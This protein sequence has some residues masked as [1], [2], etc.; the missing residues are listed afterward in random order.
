MLLIMILLMAGRRAVAVVDIKRRFVIVV[1]GIANSS[2]KAT[3]GGERGPH[4]PLRVVRPKNA[5]IAVA[6][7]RS[8]TVGAGAGRGRA[9]SVAVVR[10][11]S[12]VAAAATLPP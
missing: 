9:V 4:L 8:R 1:F 11:A 7:V 5:V 10:A 2:S 12:L 3:C 6:A